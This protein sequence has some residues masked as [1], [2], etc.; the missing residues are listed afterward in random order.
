MQTFICDLVGRGG[1]V[2]SC[3]VKTH[4]LTKWGCCFAGT[5]SFL[6]GISDEMKQGHREHLFAVSKDNLINAADK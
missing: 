3:S 6:Y 5:G 2:S 4:M 1:V